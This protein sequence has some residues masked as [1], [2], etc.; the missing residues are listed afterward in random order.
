MVQ[1]THVQYIHSEQTQHINISWNCQ[2]GLELYVTA[3]GDWRPSIRSVSET[4]EGKGCKNHT[5]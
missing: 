4:D 5:P 3:A 1:H 2:K